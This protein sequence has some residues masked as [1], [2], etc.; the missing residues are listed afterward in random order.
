M[1]LVTPEVETEIEAEVGRDRHETVKLFTP[2]FFSPRFRFGVDPLENSTPIS[3]GMILG[4]PG[5]CLGLAWDISLFL[6]ISDTR[7]TVT[8]HLSQLSQSSMAEMEAIVMGLYHHLFLILLRTNKVILSY[9]ISLNQKSKYQSFAILSIPCFK[10]K[11]AALGAQQPILE[12][13]S[14][15]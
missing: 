13:A 12:Y 15:L 7:L 4:I 11:S 8:S 9:S 5:I 2:F 6:S 14:L 10:E 3:R 1:F